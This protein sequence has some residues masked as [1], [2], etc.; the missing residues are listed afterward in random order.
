[1]FRSSFAIMFFLGPV[2]RSRACSSE[3]LFLKLKKYAFSIQFDIIS[4]NI[5]SE[6]KWNSIRCPLNN[7]PEN[8]DEV[9]FSERFD[10]CLRHF[11]DVVLCSP[12]DNFQVSRGTWLWA[13][14]T[15]LWYWAEWERKKWREIRV[16]L[17]VD[18]TMR[19]NRRRWNRL[20]DYRNIEKYLVLSHSV[21]FYQRQERSVMENKNSSSRIGSRDWSHPFLRTPRC[22]S[23]SRWS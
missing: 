3:D 19:V 6:L 17:G 18:I 12:F 2:L 7:K 15:L 21:I 16:S 8:Q 13:V 11:I 14:M 22:W 9:A 4:T 1:M 10:K 23:R 20:S 5:Q